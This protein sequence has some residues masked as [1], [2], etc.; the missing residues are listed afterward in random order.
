MSRRLWGCYSVKDHLEPRAFVADLLLYDRLVVP[1]PTEDDMA[2]WEERWD[3]VLQ[4][5]LL[6]IAAPFVERVPWDASLRDEFTREYSPATAAAEIDS[7]SRHAAGLDPYELT[8]QFITER[9]RGD[10]LHEEPSGDIRAVAVYAQPDRFDRE[11]AVTGKFPFFRK[12]TRVAPGVLREVSDVQPTDAQKLAKL[13]VTRLVVPDDGRDD[14]D[15][16]QKTVELISRDDVA[17]R[18]ADFQT[19]IAKFHAAGLRDETIVGEIEDLLAAFNASIKSRTHAQRSQAAL[20]FA[21]A[22]EGA[23]AL[24][25][26]PIAVITG[27]TAVFG[28]ALI[29][30]RWDQ[31][32]AHEVNAVSLLAEAQR[33]LKG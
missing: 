9:I 33:A 29:Q 22:A 10:V 1:V 14:A 32:T 8:R 17:Q 2:R 31:T 16:L 15:V 28:E 26:P 7:L 12:K 18:R 25:V 5:T 11:W 4:K 21:T 23:A 30:R 6:D 27:P 3:P 24:W 19:V 20:Q 13:V